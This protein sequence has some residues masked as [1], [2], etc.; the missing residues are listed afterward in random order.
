M[1]KNK[2][3]YVS[4]ERGIINFM[5]ISICNDVLVKSMQCKNPK[6]KQGDFFNWSPPQNHK[7]FWVPKRTL[8]FFQSWKKTE[9]LWGLKKLVIL[10]GLQSWKKESPESPKNSF[11][12]HWSPPQNHKCPPTRSYPAAKVL[13]PATSVW[14]LV[15]E[16]RR[17]S[18]KTCDLTGAIL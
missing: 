3:K 8:F 14:G 16:S 13:S 18:L 11:F 5:W 6:P 7:F 9:F 12:F 4:L 2:K 1:K 17:H 10:R 15:G